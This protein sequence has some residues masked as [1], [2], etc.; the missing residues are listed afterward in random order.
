MMRNLPKQVWFSGRRDGLTLV[1]LI[2]DF[3]SYTASR[4][5]ECIV[6]RIAPVGAGRPQNVHPDSFEDRTTVSACADLKRN[7]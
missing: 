4:N 1:E 5:H 6:H 7:H 2:A 3:R